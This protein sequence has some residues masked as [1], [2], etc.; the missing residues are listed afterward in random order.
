MN[1]RNNY[2]FKVRDKT[3]YNICLYQRLCILQSNYEIEIGRIDLCH[4]NTNYNQ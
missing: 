3:P 1:I 4:I 2:W